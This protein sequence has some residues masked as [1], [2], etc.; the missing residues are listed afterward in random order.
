VVPGGDHA[1]HRRSLCL[2]F[3]GLGSCADVLCEG[4]IKYVSQ[5]MFGFCFKGPLGVLL[6]LEVY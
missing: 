5:D 2:V 1:C 3:Q 6:L 4:N